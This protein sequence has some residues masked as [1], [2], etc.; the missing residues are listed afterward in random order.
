MYSGE[1]AGFDE[2]FV[3]VQTKN[4]M[5]EIGIRSSRFANC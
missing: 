3:G 5:K 4:R 1:E 2:S